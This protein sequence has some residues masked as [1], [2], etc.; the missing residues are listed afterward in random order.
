MPKMQISRPR[1]YV[2]A[3]ELCCRPSGWAGDLNK[4]QGW[5]C[6][7]LEIIHPPL[8][9]HLLFSNNNSPTSSLSYNTCSNNC[10]NSNWWMP[11]FKCRSRWSAHFLSKTLLIWASKC[12]SSSVRSL[13]C[14]QIALLISQSDS[15]EFKDNLCLHK[16]QLMM[17]HAC[18]EN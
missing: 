2:V 6:Q 1:I 10:N 15:V 11:L 16:T 3:Q 12:Q 9:L 13:L 8:R 14:P 18:N 7:I 4:I 5:C 17:S